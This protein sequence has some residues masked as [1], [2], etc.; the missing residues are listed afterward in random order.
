[1]K[2]KSPWW[3]CVELFITGDEL[4]D[5]PTG[6]DFHCNIQECGQVFKGCTPNKCNIIKRHWK[7]KH[8]LLMEKKIFPGIYLKNNLC[9]FKCF[10]FKIFYFSISIE[11][12]FFIVVFLIEFFITANQTTL[13]ET[14]MFR[15]HVR[16][17]WADNSIAATEVTREMLM[18]FCNC[19][20]PFHIVDTAAWKSFMK[21]I[22]PSYR[23][24]SSSHLKESVLSDVY[25]EKK[26]KLIAKLNSANF[27]NL[28]TD[29][30]TSISQVQYITLTIQWIGENFDCNDYVLATR[31][32]K[33]EHTSVKIAETIRLILKYDRLVLKNFKK[34]LF[35]FLCYFS[36]TQLG[37]LISIKVE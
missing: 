9:I 29:S 2:L 37:S 18:L 17:Q 31:H 34:V 33:G 14:G 12:L 16:F 3:R 1:L 22:V 25:A 6:C 20:L 23:C 32:I 5:F 30:W 28:T 26:A 13:D 15:E 24:A 35:S 4:K 7:R 10:G 19:L 11:F 36:F 21:M 27:I 8:P